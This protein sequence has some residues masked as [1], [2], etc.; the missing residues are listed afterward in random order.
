LACF[1]G[2]Y[3]FPLS[4]L[5]PKEDPKKMKEQLQCIVNKLG[6]FSAKDKLKRFLEIII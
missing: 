6:P 2:H 4:P 1:Q 5:K 3:S